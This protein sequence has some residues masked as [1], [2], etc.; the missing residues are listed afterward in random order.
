MVEA[1]AELGKSL[2]KHLDRTGEK[3][4]YAE[5]VSSLLKSEDAPIPLRS[6]GH[7]GLAVGERQGPGRAPESCAGTG[8]PVGQTGKN[9]AAV[10]TSG[11]TSSAEPPPTASAPA[12]AVQ[13]T[14]AVLTSSATVEGTP[15][16]P[17]QQPEHILRGF[18][19]KT[20]LHV[21][22]HKCL[23]PH[24]GVL[25]MQKLVHVLSACL[26]FLEFDKVKLLATQLLDKNPASV[27]ELS[28]SLVWTLDTAF[29]AAHG[30]Y[31][32]IKL[33]ENEELERY[34]HHKH[35]IVWERG[36]R[37]YGGLLVWGG[38][39]RGTRGILSGFFILQGVRG[40][41]C[42]QM[43]CELGRRT[44]TFFQT[45]T[46]FIMISLQLLVLRQYEAIKL[47]ENEELERYYCIINMLLSRRTRNS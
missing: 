30:E 45:I 31:E 42:E 9:G 7:F 2:I 41:T 38:G 24:G 25:D 18:S 40:T 1:G 36:T 17:P 8:P 14:A 15:P 27:E 35:V 13:T 33:A 19:L 3:V 6:S 22:G 4:V 11:G 39:V 37:M 12:A 21:A 26:E 46:C 28:E 29:L 43:S 10:L 34:P 20:A 47:A 23:G 5:W 44:C 32:A 16:E